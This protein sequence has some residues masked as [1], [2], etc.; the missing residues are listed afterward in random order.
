VDSIQAVVL[1][2][3]QGL[4]EFLPVSS[5][6]HLILVPRFLG[7]PDQGLAFDVA[8]HMGTLV[9]VVVYFR[10]ELG[11]L[12][13][14]WFKS[15]RGGP[16]SADS[17]MAWAIII[18]AIPVAIVGLIFNDYIETH[19][20]DSAYAVAGA[21]AFFGLLLW[22]ADRLGRKTLHTGEI[23]WSRA[24]VIG[25]A[26]ALSLWP[27]TSRSGVTMTAALALGFT[28]TAAA[29]FSFLLAVP[30]I[31]MAGAYEGLQLAR[32]G[33][34]VDWQPM[35]IGVGVAAVSGFV[36]I[37][38][39]MKLIT[40]IGFLPFAVYRWVLAAVVLYALH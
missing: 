30:S 14:A 39:F 11:A 12:I 33:H 20:R 38:Y 13:G 31:G 9:A 16:A 36:C 5:S 27:G 24:L 17:R 32:G 37:H 25:L 18:A 15:V 19:L 28:R 22:L 35:A 6:G 3:V 21:L 2:L 26:Q 8:V 29:R 40:R 34:A 23:N 10:K 1:A 7:W 4:T